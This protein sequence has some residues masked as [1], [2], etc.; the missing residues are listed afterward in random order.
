MGRI[1]V[2]ALGSR[3][4]VEPCIAVARELRQDDREVIILALENFR[5]LIEAAG[6]GF[7]SLGASM[8][9]PH[10]TQGIRGWPFTHAH[11]HQLVAV[12]AVQWWM[13]SI[14]GDVARSILR[15]VRPSDVLIS[16]ILTLDSALA[17]RSALGCRVAV[18][19][20]AP[21]LPTRDGASLIEAPAPARAS[22][23]NRWGG[24]VAWLAGARWSHPSGKIVRHALGLARSPLRR[25][26]PTLLDAPVLLA[27]S[28]ILVPPASDWPPHVRLTGP[29]TYDAAARQ[30]PSGELLEFLS[31]GPP[32]LFIGFGSV[33]NQA[34]SQLF[35]DASRKAGVRIVCSLP[36]GPG[37]AEGFADRDVYCVNELPHGWLFPRVAGV[38]HHGS[39]GTTARALQACV[40]S[41]AIPHGFDQNYYAQR[42][43]LLGV[44]PAAVPRRRLNRDTLADIMQAMTTGPAARG[45]RAQAQKI[46]REAARERGT[47][48]AVSF[49]RA[50]GII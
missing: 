14:A 49:L 20:F 24:T 36:P 38:I 47:A 13:R 31:R 39:A 7:A 10:Q 16:G 19:V 25:M 32:P 43:S 3:G 8:P 41:A 34:D 15:C 11:Q 18:A 28:T 30:A 33:G 45:Y 42:L 29:W 48:E 40:P 46:G 17:L 37:S 22:L 12:E 44:G 5:Q 21:C 23:M 26:T 35:T 2:L 50:Q 4:D 9:A 27:A 6:V 1:V